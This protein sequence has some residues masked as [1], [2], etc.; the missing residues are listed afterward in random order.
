[1][2]KN[3]ESVHAHVRVCIQHA[4]FYIVTCGLS[5]STI[6]FQI[7]SHKWHNLLQKFSEH[8]CVLIFSTFV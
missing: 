2:Y 7:I 4:L 3:S 5:G 1:M 6:F 8:K